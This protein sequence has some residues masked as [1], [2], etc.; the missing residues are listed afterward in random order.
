MKKSIFIKLSIF[1]SL[2]AFS[3][4][5]T[6]CSDK[7]KTKQ[8]EMSKEDVSFKENQKNTILEGKLTDHQKYLNEDLIFQELPTQNTEDGPA[9]VIASDY[10]MLYSPDNFIFQNDG[11]AIIK[12]PNNMQGEPIPFATLVNISYNTLKNGDVDLNPY[13]KKMFNF[14]DNWNWF[15]EVKWNGKRGFVFGADLYGIDYHK[16]YNNLCYCA[17]LYRTDGKL[18]EFYPKIGFSTISEKV[19]DN[20]SNNR[21]AFVKTEPLKNP[22][23]DDLI[24]QY[25]SVTGKEQVSVFITTDLLSHCQHLIFDRLLQHIEEKYLFANLLTLTEELCAKVQEAE[26]IPDELKKASIN[27]LTVPLVILYKEASAIIAQNGE[28]TLTTRDLYSLLLDIPAEIQEVL[29]LIDNA[30]TTAPITLFGNSSI[31]EDFSQYKVRGHYNKNSTLKAYFKANMWLSRIHF[32]LDSSSENFS[33]D[34]AKIA[35]FIT[36]LVNKNPQL[37]TI[38]KNAH[39]PITKLIGYS[40]DITIEEMLDFWKKENIEDFSAWINS[41]EELLESCSRASQSL[42]APHIS[43]VIVSKDS[44]DENENKEGYSNSSMGFRLLGQRFTWDSYIFSEISAPKLENRPFVKAMDIMKVFSSKSAERLNLEEYK[45]YEGLKEKLDLLQAKFE[46][47]EESFWSTTYYMQVL[48]QIKSLCN[49]EQGAGFYFTESPWW[50]I[51]SLIT[52]HATYAEIKHDTIL[53][54]KQSYAEKGGD[55]DFEATFRTKKL[56]SAKNYLEPNKDFWKASRK[57]IEMLKEIVSEYNF[58]TIYIDNVLTS[59]EE[60]YQKL[61]TISEQEE[62]DIAIPEEDNKWLKVLPSLLEK[63]IFLN[64]ENIYIED[65]DSLRMACIADVF[66]N[67]FYQK[68]LEVATGSPIKMYV[69]LNDINGKRISIGY[70]FSYYEFYQNQNERLNDQEWNENIY[71]VD[72]I[73]TEDKMPDWEKDILLPKSENFRIY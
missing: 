14:Q 27:Y 42:R 10:A 36:D 38:W 31:M 60:I 30:E 50:D 63:L 37:L 1:V 23:P 57:S 54:S 43:S 48:R 6:S 40:D 8:I 34:L 12:N 28:N 52:S 44:P 71:E 59:L 17:E 45:S 15:Y 53:Y 33:I 70:I 26:G 66:T 64:E 46:E 68:T 32:I 72:T 51:K 24:S 29:N 39:D 20:L 7:N 58:S 5:A 69:A 41:E 13:C 62:Y 9:A 25:K 65:T 4:S 47:Q 22:Y 3:L 21:L 56:P 18:Q 73:G 67:S 35:F 49:F 55:G 2:L 61:E 11:T 19:K 16:T